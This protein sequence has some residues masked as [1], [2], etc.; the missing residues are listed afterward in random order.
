MRHICWLVIPGL[1]GTAAAAPVP[2]GDIPGG[3]AMV[4]E[5]LLNHLDLIGCD[6]ETADRLRQQLRGSGIFIGIAVTPERTR[7]AEASRDAII[8]RVLGMAERSPKI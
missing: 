2:D 4:A 5:L 1:I 7:A 3:P 6:L 8:A